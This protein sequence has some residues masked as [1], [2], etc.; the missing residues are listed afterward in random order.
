MPDS[1]TPS[2]M[3]LMALCAVSCQTASLNAVFDETLL[4]DFTIP[5][6]EIYFSEVVSKI[7]SSIPRP[8]DLDHLRSFGLLAV[9]SLRRG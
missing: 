5:D 6:S 8:S 2:Y 3:L 4:Q 7:S 9:Y 1:N